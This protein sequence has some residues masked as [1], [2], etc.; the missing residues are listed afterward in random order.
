MTQLPLA[1]RTKEIVGREQE[2]QAIRQTIADQPKTYVLAFIGPGGIGKTRLLE[3]VGN[4]MGVFA[5]DGLDFVWSGIVDLYYPETHSNSGME[6]TIINGLSSNVPEIEQYFEDYWKEREKFERLRRE[7]IGA[8]RLEELRAHLTQTFVQDYNRIAAQHRM[9][10]AFDTAELIQFESDVIQRVCQ[11]E[12]EAIIVKGWLVDVIPHMANTVVL[13]A[14]RA[15][16]ESQEKLWADFHSTFKREAKKGKLVFQTFEL[17]GF[18]LRESLDYFD[19]LTAIARAEGR[20]EEAQAIEQLP[21]E[22]RYILHECTDGRPVRLG[23]AIDL[24]V[25]GKDISDLLPPPAEDGTT[26]KLTWEQIEPRM[27]HELEELYLDYPVGPILRHLAVTR[28]GLDASLLRYLEPGRSEHDCR[29]WLQQMMAFSFVKTRPGGDTLFLHD[30]MYELLERHW[31]LPEQPEQMAWARS[32]YAEIYRKIANYYENQLSE[33]EGDGEHEQ[34]LMIKILHYRLRADSKQG[35]E[36]Y[37]KWDEFAIKGHQAGLDMRLRDQAL[38]F[39]NVPGNQRLSDLQ[40]LPRD[41]IDRDCAVRWVKRYSAKAQ[42]SRAIEVAETILSFGPE[43]YRSLVKKPPKAVRTIKGP[44]RKDARRIFGVDDPLFWAHLLATYS[45]VL[46]FHGAPEAQARQL[47]DKTVELLAAG[48]EEDYRRWWRTRILARAYNRLGYAH[49]TT[50]RYRL[51]NEYN[52]TALHYYRQLDIRDEMAETLNNAAYVYAL[53]GDISRAEKWIDDALEL[54]RELRQ[55]YPLALS[56]NT[57]G[58]IHLQAGEPHRALPRCKEALSVC[59]GLED[60][61]G[62]GMAYNA[63]GLVYRKVGNLNRLGVYK[64]DQA[65]DFYKK[66]EDAL[67]AAVRIF[68][69]EV[70]ERIRRVVAYNELGSVHRDWAILLQ[71]AG[72]EE[73]ATQRF[74]QAL[75]SYEEAI[76]VAEDEWP[77]DRAD[78][79]EDMADVF[80]LQGQLDRAEEYLEKAEALVPDEYRLVEGGGFRE[81][82]EP[83]EGFWQIMGKVHLARGHNISRP[84]RG[85]ESL[86]EEQ[87]AVL[88]KAVE[89]YA[90]AT[91][92]FLQYSP[93]LELHKET[94][95]AVYDR[96]KRSGI[97]RLE[98]A[99]KQVL[100]V[101]DRFKVDLGPLLAEIDETLGLKAPT[102]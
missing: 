9:V 71:E 80:A 44:L 40:G 87:E 48:E 28:L 53:L 58:L 66:A 63:L 55:G 26:P 73:E 20:K 77:V 70:P 29:N 89:Q 88:L 85:L 57:R 34:E 38:R 18:T 8:S 56:L 35:Y 23:L 4:P 94:F 27:I 31:I 41:A 5:I 82:T 39:H 91:A 50:R 13:L 45:E 61:R 83:V 68:K 81:I 12:E 51:S 47:L 72:Q 14:G 76:R 19:E 64:F 95:E 92:Y 15:E 65:L 49:W 86:T 11:V 52:H 96:L 21:S 2:L 7:M 99:E 32:K 60:W 67:H 74:E 84:I 16:T 54:R 24:A 90:L 78:S 43:P 1:L 10:L 6:S 93:H 36:N 30:E 22:V 33:L 17:K 3:E 37:A 75:A 69:E 97:E 59:Q 100:V 25:H 79:Y 101:A 98:K 42:Y 46:L 102:L 62:Q